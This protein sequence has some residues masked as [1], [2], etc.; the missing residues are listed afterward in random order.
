MNL[1]IFIEQALFLRQLSVE[2]CQLEIN[3][4]NNN[5]E[6]DRMSK[7]VEALQWRIRNHF[8][9]PVENLTPETCKQE[10]QEHQRTSL[11]TLY[12]DQQR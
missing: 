1:V 10:Y 3:M 5:K 7:N 6:V 12:M 9:V 2:K 4:T 11:P 8:D